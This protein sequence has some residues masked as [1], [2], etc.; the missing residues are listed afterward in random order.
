M[1]QLHKNLREDAQNNTADELIGNLEKDCKANY[2]KLS[3]VPSESTYT[4]WIPGTGHSRKF[5]IKAQ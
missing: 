2:I 3:V 5:S 1:Y 4:V